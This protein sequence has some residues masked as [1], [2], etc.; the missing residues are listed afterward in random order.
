MHTL[1]PGTGG[2]WPFRP[3]PQ[4]EAGGWGE[5]P[6]EET[7]GT[8]GKGPGAAVTALWGAGTVP[9]FKRNA[10]AGAQTW[11]LVLPGHQWDGGTS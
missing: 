5:L 8:G 9:Q 2:P 11:S 3:G 4:A 6:G 10:L 1:L 7:P